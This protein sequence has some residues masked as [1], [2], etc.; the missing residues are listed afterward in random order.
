MHINETISATT[1]VRNLA[2]AVNHVRNTGKSISITKGKQS[3]AILA[4][5]PK[6]GLS[7]NQ[8]ISMI[9]RLPSLEQDCEDFSEDLN[10]IRKATGLPDNLWD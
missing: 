6:A 2:E 1:L 10:K 9:E 7:V 4:P 3:I 5:P 8:L